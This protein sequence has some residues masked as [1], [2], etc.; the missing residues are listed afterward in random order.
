MLRV[1]PYL[2]FSN[3]CLFRWR[4]SLSRMTPLKT[5]SSELSTHPFSLTIKWPDIS[6]EKQPE[7]MKS[8][9]RIENLVMF[10]VIPNQQSV[11]NETNHSQMR[12]ACFFQWKRE[13]EERKSQSSFPL[14][15]HVLLVI[16]RSTWKVEKVR[17]RVTPNYIRFS[18]CYSLSS[19]VSLSYSFKQRL[20]S[21]NSW[22]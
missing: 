20:Q 2:R 22:I 8:K 9:W 6:E 17:E 1:I 11:V 12:A 19:L 10:Q 5:L 13:R 16:F 14:V 7:R 15:C 18:I 4:Q 21:Q 3:V